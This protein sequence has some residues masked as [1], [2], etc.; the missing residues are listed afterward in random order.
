ML[1]GW[2][3]VSLISVSYG[4]LYSANKTVGLFLNIGISLVFACSFV[5][6]QNMENLMIFETGNFCCKIEWQ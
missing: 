2:D 5:C 1:S 3:W 4:A 6:C